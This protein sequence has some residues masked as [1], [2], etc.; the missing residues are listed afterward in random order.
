ML[1]CGQVTLVERMAV[2]TMLCKSATDR[3]YLAAAQ[4]STFTSMYLLPVRRSASAEDKP[5]TYLTAASIWP[6]SRS[7]V[8][9]RRR[10]RSTFRALVA[11]STQNLVSLAA[12]PRAAH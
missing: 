11:F 6:V 7:I 1:V 9:S 8:A 4:R 12:G 10:R 5:G 3:P 2:D